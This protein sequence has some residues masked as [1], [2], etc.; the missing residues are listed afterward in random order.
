MRARRFSGIIEA[1]DTVGGASLFKRLIRGMPGVFLDAVAIA[2]V[3]GFVSFAIGQSLPRRWF[4]FDAFPYRDFAWEKKGKIYDRVR[5][6]KWKDWVPDMSRFVPFMV[7]KKAA[8]ARTPEAMARLIKETCVAEVVHWGLIAIV[9]PVIA[10]TSGG[11]FGAL[12]GA[13]YGTCNLSFVIIQRYNR[14]R[15]R[16]ILRRMEERRST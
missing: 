13:V 12:L 3:G 9:S 11:A 2:V 8:L 15:L 4:D 6:H 10:L 16:E 5:V 7:K 1:T 14:P